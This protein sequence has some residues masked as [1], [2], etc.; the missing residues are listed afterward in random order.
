MHCNYILQ[1][2]SACT[3]VLLSGQIEPYHCLMFSVPVDP[4]RVMRA[5]RFAARFGFGLDENAREAIKTQSVCSEHTHLVHLPFYNHTE[6]PTEHCNTF[7]LWTKAT[8]EDKFTMLH[9][10][11]VPNAAILDDTDA[12][13]SLII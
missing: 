3:H 5:I 2:F 10:A 9:K 7:F 6:G 4:L 13:I 1:S 12:Y 8:S 11:A